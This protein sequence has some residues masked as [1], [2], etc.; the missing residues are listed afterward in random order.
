MK[1][2]ANNIHQG[3]VLIYRDELYVVTKPP[4]RAKP[5]KG[6]A[7][8][9]VEMKSLK[10]GTKVNERFN[11][12][13]DVMKARLETK[14]FQ[15]LYTQDDKII[16]MDQESYDQ[17]EINVDM[18]GEKIAF[19]AENM[20]LAVEM[21]E[22]DPITV[23]LPDSV[24]CEVVE[25]EPVTKGQTVTSSYKPGILDNGLRVL[26]PPFIEAG[27]KIVVKTEDVTYVERAK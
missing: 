12:S 7:Y 9:Q 1:I 6:P 24:V 14:D 13:E 22:D 26:I 10:H 15:Y 2:S 25:C 27:T 11:T 8:V 19:L 5:G 17:I 4:V 20:I 3:N 18:L 21:N 16:L 23:R